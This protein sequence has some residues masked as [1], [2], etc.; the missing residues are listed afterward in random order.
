MFCQN[1]A[2]SPNKVH[3][4]FCWCK[5]LMLHIFRKV[6]AEVQAYADMVVTLWPGASGAMLRIFYLRRRFL[7]LGRSPTISSGIDVAGASSICIGDNFFCGKGC[8]LYADG[9]GE[10]LIGNRV[11][12]NANV[13]VNAAINGKIVIGDHV[14]V[15]PGVLMRA[16]DHAFSRT[17]IPIWQQGHVPGTIQID[18]DVW[19]GG[20]VTILGGAC[21]GKGAVVAAGAVVNGDVPAYAV[22]GGVPA[23][24]LRWRDNRSPGACAAGE[25]KHD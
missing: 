24:L 11:A 21:I 14:L 4:P 8:T 10:I 20:N 25:H 22:V 16:T 7:F 2:P 23:K 6:L 9:G 19:I 17:D 5:E 1:I 13:S 3:A 12:F 15:G 18:D